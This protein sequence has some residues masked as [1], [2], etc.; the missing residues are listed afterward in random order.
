[1]RLPLTHIMP[2]D[3]LYPLKTF[4]FLFSGG[5]RKTPVAWN[6]L[7]NEIL[8]ENYFWTVTYEILNGRRSKFK[9]IHLFLFGA[10]FLLQ[11]TFLPFYFNTSKGILTSNLSVWILLL[12]NSEKGVLICHWIKDVRIHVSENQYSRIFMQFL[13][14]YLK[15]L[16]IFYLTQSD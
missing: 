12:P 9:N 6:G 7:T 14:L 13:C 4:D 11:T 1:M 8:L 15:D 3:S 5:Y 10:P 2:L 16:T